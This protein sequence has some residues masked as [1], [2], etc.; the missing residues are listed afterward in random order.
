MSGLVRCRKVSR[1]QS[2]MPSLRVGLADES[3][4]G[5]KL[6]QAGLRAQGR[7]RGTF[8]AGQ[9]IVKTTS[10]GPVCR[11]PGGRDNDV[12]LSVVK[13]RTGRN[14]VESSREQLD[15]GR[16]CVLY[17]V[18]WEAGPMAHCC[19]SWAALASWCDLRA[20]IAS[21]GRRN[22][23]WDPPRCCGVR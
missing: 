13:K 8:E 3:E 21:P 18:M 23:I 17:G 20:G 5:A 6:A 14:P 10:E 1:P 4:G 2:G 11:L 15:D 12:L 22:R 9:N 16:R 19:T 7:S